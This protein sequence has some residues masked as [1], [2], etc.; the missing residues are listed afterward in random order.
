MPGLYTTGYK[1]FYKNM[2]SWN[3]GS[4]YYVGEYV[5]YNF[6]TYLCISDVL[7]LPPQTPDL[8]TGNWVSIADGSVT[9]D[10]GDKFVTSAT[11]KIY[12]YF[13]L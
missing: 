4:Y 13:Y 6:V 10:F 9:S 2:G 3:S 7:N 12:L 5:S 1:F 8:A 11:S